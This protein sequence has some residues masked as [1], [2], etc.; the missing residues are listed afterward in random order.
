MET[1]ILFKI[2]LKD[3]L[4]KYSP[5]SFGYTSTIYRSGESIIKEIY[6]ESTLEK[7]VKL[8]E[9]L[10]NCYFATHPRYGRYSVPFLGYD[11]Y[12]KTLLLKFKYMGKN[13]EESILD[14]SS[15]ELMKIHKNITHALHILNKKVIH[16]DLHIANIFVDK[17]SLDVFIG[18]WGRGLLEPD[19]DNQD[20]DFYLYSFIRTIKLA[21]FMKFYKKIP[22]NYKIL[23]KKI[24]NEM[25]YTKKKFPHKPKSFY[26][27]LKLYITDRI[28]KIMIER[29]PEYK[30]EKY[31]PEDIKELIKIL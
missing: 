25:E 23:Q 1:L 19:T 4:Q 12:D 14:Y 8:N 13:L 9:L 21:Y 27:K 20:Y 26:P 24:D 5:Y 11:T 28:T 16:R 10:A 29:T 3:E 18:D 17:N 15:K 7:S 31:L 22:I 30:Q 6:L 2:N